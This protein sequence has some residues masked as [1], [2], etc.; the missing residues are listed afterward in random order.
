MLIHDRPTNS[1]RRTSDG[2][3]NPRITACYGSQS[4]AGTGSYCTT[5][6]NTLLC[7][8]HPGASERKR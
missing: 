7:R 2:G 6:Q 8:A 3:S 5:T 4:G 1:A